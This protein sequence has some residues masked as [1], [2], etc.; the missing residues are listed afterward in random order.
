VLAE[1]SWRP[2]AAALT[3]L[4]GDWHSQG[5]GEDRVPASKQDSVQTS[6]LSV[7]VMTVWQGWLQT[8]K[9]WLLML[10]LLQAGGD[11]AAAS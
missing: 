6:Q 11:T 9:Q 10:L 5:V 1:T 4:A 7:R 8:G 3:A 2:A